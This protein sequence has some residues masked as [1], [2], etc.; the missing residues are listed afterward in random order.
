MGCLTWGAGR[1]G[2][3]RWLRPGVWSYVLVEM[4]R[5]CLIAVAVFRGVYECVL[6]E[7]LC[8][9]IG[10]LSSSVDLGCGWF[11]CMAG[12]GRVAARVA[13]LPGLFWI[14]EFWLMGLGR[15][16]MSMRRAFGGCLGTRRR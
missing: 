5:V 15:L 8:R 12:F 13:M 9:G 2:L 14:D 10:G 6:S 16:L 1:W 11:L 7:W 4:G 3:R